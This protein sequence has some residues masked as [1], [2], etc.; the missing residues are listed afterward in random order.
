[1]KNDFMSMMMIVLLVVEVFVIGYWSHRG[2]IV[3]SS[4]FQIC[5]MCFMKSQRA[6][7][8]GSVSG[9]GGNSSANREPEGET[10][11]I[12]TIEIPGYSSNFM[13]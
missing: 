5:K 11:L 10:K 3:R 9:G 7:L 8:A 6:K 2:L 13:R 4:C 1:M 12:Q